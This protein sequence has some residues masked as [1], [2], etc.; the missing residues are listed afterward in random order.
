MRLYPLA[1]KLINENNTQGNQNKCVPF[2]CG[3]FVLNLN[4]SPEDR[5]CVNNC[6]LIENQ[7]IQG[8]I[9]DE[10]KKLHSSPSD[11]LIEGFP[12][13]LDQA[14]SLQKLKFYPSKVIFVNVSNENLK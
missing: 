10:I 11:C 4:L 7:E 12:K 9:I 3:E 2:N 8:K 13:S 14:L 5:K 1:E 6:R